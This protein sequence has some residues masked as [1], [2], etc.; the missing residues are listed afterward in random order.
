MN[1]KPIAFLI[2]G[3]IIAAA[4]VIAISTG[5]S[6]FLGR[7]PV[8]ASGK[9]AVIRI[10]GIILSSKDVI[11]QLKKYSKNPS[12]KAIVLRINSPGGAVVPSQEIY[13]EINKVRAKTGK[14][15]VVSMGTV[16]ASGGYYI[17]SAAD[18][19]LANPGTLT[20]SIGVIMEF[21][22]V[23]QLLKK[24]GIKDQTIASGK[25]KDVGDFMRTMTP[26]EKEYLKN[27]LRDVHGQ[28]VEAVAKG[29]KMKVDDVWALA[30]GSVYT[31]RQAQKLGLVDGLGDLQ[32]AISAAGKMAGIKGRPAVIT[33]EKK[34]SIWDFIKGQNAGSLFQG[35]IGKNLQGMMYL[36]A[37]PEIR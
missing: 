29:R 20:G 6:L 32:D 33:E 14:K 24:I 1:R 34:T 15:I 22:S 18:R 7:A 23:E 8:A 12:V 28:F 31:G 10:D 25:R 2:V 37:A 30:D 36:Y 16:A 9:V 35:L 21:A 26:D 3:I 4:L 19:I 13:E 5:A 27:V 11:H 17:A